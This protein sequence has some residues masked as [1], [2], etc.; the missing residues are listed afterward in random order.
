MAEY[1]IE[2]IR[3]HGGGVRMIQGFRVYMGDI[4]QRQQELIITYIP[5]LVPELAQALGELLRAHGSWHNRN[6][7]EEVLKNLQS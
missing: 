6:R 3:G 1:P 7:I 4:T 2:T 5:T